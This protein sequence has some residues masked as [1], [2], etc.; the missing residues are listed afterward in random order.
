MVPHIGIDEFPADTA[1][2]VLSKPTEYSY[3]LWVISG[4][5]VF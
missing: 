2:M 5:I 3:L 4:W 1:A